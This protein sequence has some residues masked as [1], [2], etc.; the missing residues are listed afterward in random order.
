MAQSEMLAQLRCDGSGFDGQDR[1]FAS[2]VGVGRGW[3]WRTGEK[4]LK[5]E[6]CSALYVP[7]LPATAT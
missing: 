2:R 1:R 5:S 6:P 4:K 7:A 3:R